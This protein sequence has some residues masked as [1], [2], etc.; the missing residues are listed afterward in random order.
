MLIRKSWKKYIIFC[1]TLALCI[2]RA[3]IAYAADVNVTQTMADKDSVTISWQ[4]SGIDTY[5]VTLYDVQGTEIAFVTTTDG[6]AVFNQLTAGTVYYVQVRLTAEETVEPI[7]LNNCTPVYTKP[8]D[9][10]E[11]GLAVWYPSVKPKGTSFPGYKANKVK[12]EW[13][14]DNYSDG[15]EL[16]IYSLKGKKLKEYDVQRQESEYC[17]KEFTNKSI[18]NQGFIARIR[19]YKIIADQKYYSAFSKKITVVPQASISKVTGTAQK[20]NVYW[21]PVKGATKYMIYRIRNGKLKLLKTVGGKTAKYTVKG[22]KSGDGLAVAVKMKIKG[23][24]FTSPVTWYIS[25]D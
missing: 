25:Q 3:E 14:N 13:L 4:A 18:K 15:Y 11:F 7:S 24:N 23:K 19:S 6:S 21:M 1:T 17:T 8:A 10:S 2:L 22:L 5:R 20:R 12:M 16:I 9:V